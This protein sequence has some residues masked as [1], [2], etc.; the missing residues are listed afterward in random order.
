M[1]SA[2]LRVNKLLWRPSF[3]QIIN[4]LLTIP[5][6]LFISSYA[7]TNAL[8]IL[9]ALYPSIILQPCGWDCFNLPWLKWKPIQCHRLLL[10]AAFILCAW[11]WS[12]ASEG[13][14][15]KTRDIIQLDPQSPSPGKWVSSGG[16]LESLSESHGDCYGTPVPIIPDMRAYLGPSVSKVK[17]YSRTM[18]LW[19]LIMIT[20]EPS[21]WDM[22]VVVKQPRPILIPAVSEITNHCVLP[23]P[24][25][26]DLRRTCLLRRRFISYS[27]LYIISLVLRK[28]R[29]LAI[30]PTLASTETSGGLREK[31]VVNPKKKK[32]RRIVHASYCGYV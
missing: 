4:I 8:T 30:Y 10:D 13:K 14:G 17:Y 18:A 19:T 23:R 3:A 29:C 11:A 21:N 12:W 24:T 26:H 16:Q 25:T 28:H 27:S 15:S 20:Q 22:D 1:V 9:I 7:S 31:T 6:A 2:N 5:T 32:E